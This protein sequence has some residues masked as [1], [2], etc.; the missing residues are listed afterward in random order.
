MDPSTILPQAVKPNGSAEHVSPPILSRRPTLSRE[1][2][3]E[4]TTPPQCSLPLWSAGVPNARSVRSATS[5][6]GNVS[7]DPTGANAPTGS[8]SS[9]PTDM[10][11]ASADARASSSLVSMPPASV[12]TVIT[13][14]TADSSDTPT[15][16][17]PVCTAV[18]RTDVSTASVGPSDSTRTASTPSS[19][20]T[21]LP[22]RRLPPRST[23]SEAA[24]TSND[25]STDA[26]VSSEPTGTASTP[27]SKAPTTEVAASKE[28]G[29]AHSSAEP[30]A[31]EG[32][33]GAGLDCVEAQVTPALSRR[34]WVCDP[35]TL[36]SP[37]S[38]FVDTALPALAFGF[39]GA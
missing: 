23:V 5:T 30:A 9:P 25:A 13:T 1:V 39:A 36:R 19:V 22:D 35:L 20:T 21:S 26:I 7:A 29:E 38:S 2:G 32:E 24:S 28:M 27:L 14:D 10:S 3:R 37:G 11:T 16:G 15:C 12:T 17:A 4:P 34:S 33:M 31:T 8:T 6:S 18:P